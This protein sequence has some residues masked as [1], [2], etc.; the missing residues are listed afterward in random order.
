MFFNDSNQRFNLLIIVLEVV[1]QCVSIDNNSDR[2]DLY[3]AFLED[4]SV[5]VVVNHDLQAHQSLT[6]LFRICCL[7]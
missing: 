4:C 5:F 3:S 2:P 1:D 7:E 6:I